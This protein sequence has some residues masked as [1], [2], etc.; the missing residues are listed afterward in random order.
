MS[1]SSASLGGQG[2]T[3]QSDFGAEKANQHA[4]AKDSIELTGDDGG[5]ASARIRYCFQVVDEND[6]SIIIEKVGNS[7]EDLRTK[8]A[9]KPEAV[10]PVF[11]VVQT[12]KARKGNKKNIDDD[13]SS[14]VGFASS[15]SLKIYSVPIL[16]AL[17]SLVR[18]YPSQ[19]LIGNT[20]V[21]N[22]PYA[23]L[24]H[25][26]DELSQFRRQCLSR[27][28]QEVCDRERN[29][30]THIKLL[31]EWLDANVMPDIRAEMD[32][33]QRGAHTWA[34]SWLRLRPGN[35]IITRTLAD[36]TPRAYV[37]QGVSGGPFDQ[38]STT[39]NVKVWSLA[40]NGY[41]FSR[42]SKTMTMLAF[43]GEK[44]FSDEFQSDLESQGR[45]TRVLTRRELEN[46]E[47]LEDG[48]Q[49][50]VRRGASYWQTASKLVRW[51]N[52][53]G[54]DAPYNSVSAFSKPPFHIDSLR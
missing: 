10:K 50:L 2:D 51:Y 21:I 42:V 30:P 47:A 22:Q 44:E 35:T 52:G 25:H 29:A 43:E 48:I 11:D 5:D 36:S 24:C 4:T 26:Y 20:V 6:A 18:Y 45:R 19:S 16:N 54:A 9:T 1:D 31:L 12:I 49:S 3:P 8:S 28:P 40:W 7:Y 15:W 34:W 39:M 53:Q 17:R 27:H 41:A 14:L 33:N 23:I 38:N 13:P 46:A 37:I 32:R